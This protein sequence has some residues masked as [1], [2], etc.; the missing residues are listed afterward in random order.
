M[1]ECNL[2]IVYDI[3][4]DIVDSDP[5]LEHFE[6]AKTW[7][8]NWLSERQISQEIATWIINYKL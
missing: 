8:R 5:T 7:G 4:Y 3:V 1:N 2:T 6:Q